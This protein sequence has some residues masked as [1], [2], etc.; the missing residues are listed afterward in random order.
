MGTGYWHLSPDGSQV[1]VTMLDPINTDIFLIDVET[2]RQVNHTVAPSNDWG[3]AWSADGSRIVYAHLQ[4]TLWISEVGS[5]GAPV[6]IETGSDEVWPS[7]WSSDG[8]WLAFAASHP[9]NQRDVYA[10]NVDMPEER[11]TIADSQA[12]EAWPRFSPDGDYVAYVEDDEVY[13]VSFPVI[14]PKKAVSEVGGTVP[15]WSAAGDELFFW[16]GDSLMVTDV[17]TDGQF[18]WA[19]RSF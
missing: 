19:R 12:D 17:S 1:A 16:Q 8:N 14:G 2:G 13:V 15:M 9:L 11:I 5:L 18:Q 6:S 10:V 4:G 7:S 3:P